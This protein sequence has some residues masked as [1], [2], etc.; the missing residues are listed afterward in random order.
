MLLDLPRKENVRIIAVE[1]E[2]GSMEMSI[3]PSMVLQE[4]SVV[5]I[6]IPKSRIYDLI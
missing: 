2:D 4:D 3:D 1:Q 6:V 5:A